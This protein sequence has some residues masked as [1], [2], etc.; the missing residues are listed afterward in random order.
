MNPN[1]STLILANGRGNGGTAAGAGT[2]SAVHQ[3]PPQPTAA[4]YT[5]DNYGNS[6]TI[7]I[8][9]SLTNA[10]YGLGQYIARCSSAVINSV[11]GAFDYNFANAYDSGL[12]YSTYT[13]SIYNPSNGNMVVLKIW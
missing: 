10:G 13:N 9:S 7:N 4:T 6:S 8:T 12:W 3:Y 5:Y 1:S 11:A 2:T